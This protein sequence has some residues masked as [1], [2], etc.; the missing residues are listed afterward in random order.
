MVTLSV[1]EL[2]QLVSDQVAAALQN[3]LT[4][5]T[6]LKVYPIKEAAELIGVHFHT[7]RLYCQ[8]GIIESFKVGNRDFVTLKAIQDFIANGGSDMPTQSKAYK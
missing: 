3:H 7:V 2:K 4:P 5:P 1:N 8:K 6:P